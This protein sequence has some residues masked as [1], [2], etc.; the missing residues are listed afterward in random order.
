MSISDNRW[1]IETV[2]NFTGHYFKYLNMT[3]EGQIPQNLG[4]EMKPAL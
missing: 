3:D 1:K 4:H 2:R